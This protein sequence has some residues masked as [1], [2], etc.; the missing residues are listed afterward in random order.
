MP[1]VK[2]KNHQLK[3]HIKIDLIQ[4]DHTEELSDSNNLDNLNTGY[5]FG[6]CFFHDE[7]SAN[8]VISDNY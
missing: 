5:Q 8:E 1:T 4:D 6:M 7:D 2:D 3:E